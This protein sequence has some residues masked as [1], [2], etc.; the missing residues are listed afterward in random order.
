MSASCSGLKGDMPYLLVLCFVLQSD[1]LDID[2][3]I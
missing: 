2:I 1:C 3:L